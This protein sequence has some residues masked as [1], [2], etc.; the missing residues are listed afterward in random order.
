MARNPLPR[1]ALYLSRGRDALYIIAKE[2]LKK[3]WPPRVLVPAFICEVVPRTFISCGVEPVFYDVGLDLRPDLY[4]IAEKASKA[5][6][7]VI[8][9][10]FGFPQPGEIIHRVTDMGLAVILDD[11]QSLPLFEEPVDASVAWRINGFRKQLPL[12]DGAVLFGGL[13][14]R[15]D[16]KLLMSQ[17]QRVN[18][19]WRFLGLMLRRVIDILPQRYLIELE[20]DCFTQELRTRRYPPP[21]PMMPLSRYWYRRLDLSFFAGRRKRNY[22]LLRNRLDDAAAVDL[23]DLDIHSTDS[24]L[25]FPLLSPRRDLLLD[26]LRENRIA[27]A[28]L[29]HRPMMLGGK[30]K[31]KTERL[32][33]EVLVLPLGQPYG[34]ADMERMTKAIKL[35][36]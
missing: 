7:I 9:N 21:A 29:W 27:A 18:A 20:R 1:K 14:A 2:I 26:R 25:G 28:V 24:P 35:C 19:F 6:T 11:V 12:P 13:G 22:L 34:D 36:G 32:W 33:N 17:Q 5:R 16:E 30:E 15:L 8:V 4:D 3:G 10:Y 23:L 31:F